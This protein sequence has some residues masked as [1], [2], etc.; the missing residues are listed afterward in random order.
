MSGSKRLNGH[1]PAE[2]ILKQS[3]KDKVYRVTVQKTHVG[4]CP[5]SDEKELDFLS[6]DKGLKEEIAA[7]LSLGVPQST[8]LKQY[9]CSAQPS[10]F[11]RT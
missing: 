2:I 4:H 7:K 5:G 11:Q 10:S 1:C 6:L 3:K 9:Q 8:I